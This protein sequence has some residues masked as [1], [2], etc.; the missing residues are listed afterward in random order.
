MNIESFSYVLGIYAGMY[1]LIAILSL[2]HPLLSKATVDVWL[3]S[4][5]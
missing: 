2:L 3:R 5:K 4:L 1:V